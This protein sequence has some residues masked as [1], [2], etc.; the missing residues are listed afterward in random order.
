MGLLTSAQKT[1]VKSMRALAWDREFTV[2][3]ITQVM[4]ADFYDTPALS[5]GSVVLSGD[6]V[7]RDR[8]ET[9]GSPGGVIDTADLI[10]T[11]DI[12]NSGS[13]LES[14]AQLIVDGVRCAIR[15][16]NVYPDTGEAV[17]AAVKSK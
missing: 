11:T 12:L 13:L 6:W 10:L 9:R 3:T 1:A 4:G 5:S 17:V 7:W 14:G 15:S 8:S 2:E 16:V